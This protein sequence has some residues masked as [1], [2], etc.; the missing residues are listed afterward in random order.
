MRTSKLITIEPAPDTEIGGRQVIAL[1]CSIEEWRFLERLIHLVNIGDDN[2]LTLVC[3]IDDGGELLKV[4]LL[5]EPFM[6]ILD[7]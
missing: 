5:G 7:P 1:G 4:N 3:E 6:L 2:N